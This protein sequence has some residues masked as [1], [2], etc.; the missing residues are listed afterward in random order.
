MIRDGVKTEDGIFIESPV[1]FEWVIGE[2]IPSNANP[3]IIAAREV[4]APLRAW[5]DENTEEALVI[6]TVFTTEPVLD[7]FQGVL[8]GVDAFTLEKPS[9]TVGYDAETLEPIEAPIVSGEELEV[10]F[11]TPIAPFEYSPGIWKGRR[12]VTEEIPGLEKR[13]EGGTGHFGLEAVI[14]GS[15]VT[16]AFNYVEVDG[17]LVPSRLRFESGVAVDGGIRVQVPFVLYLCTG[18]LDA[19]ADLPVMVFAHGGGSTNRIASTPIANANCLNGVATI[20]I[21]MPFHGGRLRTTW[22]SEMRLFAATTP[23]EKNDF[24]DA[25]GVPD[26][27]GDGTSSAQSVGPLFG[28]EYDLDPLLVEATLLTISSDNYTLIR[29]LQEGDWSEVLP[30]LSFDSDRLFHGSLSFGTT[31]STNIVAMVDDFRG[32]VASVGTAYTLP[33]NLPMAPGNAV[34][35]SGLLFISLGL[36]MPPLELQEGS[37]RDPMV[38]LHAWLSGRGDSLP[39]APYVL[40]HRPS[41]KLPEILASGNSWDE[42]LFSPAQLTYSNAVGYVPYTTGDEWTLMSDIPGAETVVALPLPEEGVSGSFVAGE[43][44][45]SAAIMYSSRTCHAQLISP[46]CSEYYV[47]Q[48]PPVVP[49]EPEAYSATISSVCGLHGQIARFVG[50][51]LDGAEHGLI[52][53]P[54]DTCESLYGSGTTK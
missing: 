13:Y 37:Y 38:G 49:L 30:G 43:Q 6:A 22:M 26:Y 53:A 31:F 17:A 12:G 52:T 19:P 4:F 28:L 33:V 21:D 45:T 46:A 5:L 50:S 32:I 8:D 14:H 24:T 42:T 1:S 7:Y 48:Y 51:L 44:A 41:G 15:I 3:D 39:Y 54:N 20:A 35:A 36:A 29:L 23:D 11:G 10:Y 27:I 9:R 2:P 47:R 16:P 18:Q 34:M 25:E 40:R